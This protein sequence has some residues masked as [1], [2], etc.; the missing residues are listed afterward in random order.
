MSPQPSGSSTQAHLQFYSLIRPAF[1]E[2]PLFGMGANTFSVYY[3][4]ITG[5]TNYGP[6]S[7]YVAVITETGVV[8]ALLFLCYLAYVFQRLAA[9]R[10]LGRRLAAVGERAAARVR[11]LGW[12]LTA[13]VLGTMAANVFYLTMQMYYFYVLVVLV[14]A[15]PAVF[16]RLSAARPVATTG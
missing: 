12:G 11:P 9:L 15:A 13:A 6:H 5:R 2:H 10:A 16:G 8:G 1:Q 14:L 4:F 7:Y 3:E